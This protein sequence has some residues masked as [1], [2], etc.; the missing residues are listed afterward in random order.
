MLASRLNTIHNLWYFSD[1]MRRLRTAI[2]QGS[3]SE[4]RDAFYRGHAQEPPEALASGD[5]EAGTTRRM[6]QDI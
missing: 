1:F 4:F 6:P 5:R 2:A 3:F